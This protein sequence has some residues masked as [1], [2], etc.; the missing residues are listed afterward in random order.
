[1]S[2]LKSVWAKW[3]VSISFISGALVV[4]TTYGTCTVEPDKEAIVKEVVK[5]EDTKEE[6]EKEPE[7]VETP[8]EEPK[9]EVDTDVKEL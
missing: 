5:E 9:K 6:K 7:K 4:A 8:V 3:K 2:F 1:M